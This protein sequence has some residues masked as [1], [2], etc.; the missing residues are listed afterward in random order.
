VSVFV[1]T[2]AFLTIL[3]ADDPNNAFAT[4]AWVQSVK[5][6]E[7]LITTNYVVV[8][9]ISVLHR[10]HGLPAVRWFVDDILPVI[11]IDWV[12]QAAHDSAA[13]ALLAGSRNGPS[14][15]DCAS[16]EAIDRLGVTSV[17]A[18]DRHFDDRGFVLVGRS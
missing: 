10:R 11:H 14:L 16:F 6:D 18:Y 13:N 9:T 3:D 17:L 15:V 7:T 12:L 5:G 4:E 2:S 1:D 8:E